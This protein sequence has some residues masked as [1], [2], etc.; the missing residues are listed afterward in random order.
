MSSPTCIADVD[1]LTHG[2]GRAPIDFLEV[3]EREDFFRWPDQV[4]SP[5]KQYDG[6]RV[7]QEE[8]GVVARHEDELLARYGPYVVR[9]IRAP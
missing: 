4:E 1:V 7:G 6:L 3:F 5:V 8:R 9:Q 2:H